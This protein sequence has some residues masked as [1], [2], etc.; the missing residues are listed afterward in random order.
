MFC[1]CFGQK[2]Y[3]HSTGHSSLL[4]CSM[5]GWGRRSLL[6]VGSACWSERREEVDDDLYHFQAKAGLTS[7]LLIRGGEDIKA[8]R[9]IISLT[10][11]GE[12]PGWLQVILYLHYQHGYQDITKL[13]SVVLITITRTH[14][15]AQVWRKVIR[16]YRRL[17]RYNGGSTPV[18]IRELLLLFLPSNQDWCPG[19]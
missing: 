18:V 16:Y 4:L 11:S 17:I 3:R 12:S 7:L 13:E 2:R 15:R 10:N 14:C 9:V 6:T 5:K 8:S 1:L 19:W